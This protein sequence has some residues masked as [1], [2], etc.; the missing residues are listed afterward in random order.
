MLSYIIKYRTFAHLNEMI[1]VAFFANSIGVARQVFN[2]VFRLTKTSEGLV[3]VE[4]LCAW[5]SYHLLYL[6]KF[7]Q[8]QLSLY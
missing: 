7:Q 8:A 4:V 1:G 3:I 2:S 5:V 6:L